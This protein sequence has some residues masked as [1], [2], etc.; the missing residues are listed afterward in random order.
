MNRKRREL[1]DRM[2][3]FPPEDGEPRCGEWERFAGRGGLC[4][5]W[6]EE[7]PTP[8]W[9]TRR[10]WPGKTYRTHVSVTMISEGARPVVRLGPCPWVEARD[11][12]VTLEAALEILDNPARAL[13]PKL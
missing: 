12:D 8:E 13:K 4:V 2:L 1:L 10:Q 9:V 7:L 3:A 11:M 6:G 5:R